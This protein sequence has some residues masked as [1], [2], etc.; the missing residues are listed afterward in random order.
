MGARRIL[1]WRLLALA[2]AF[3]PLIISGC[4]TNNPQNTLQHSGDVGSRITNLF[5]PVFWLA[6][7][8]FVGVEGALCY[9]IFRFRRRP[10]QTELPHQTHG[11]TTLEITWTIIPVIVLAGIAF[12][13]LTGIRYLDRVPEN[14][15][16]VNVTA[17]QWWWAFDYP[18]SGIVTANEM[19]IPAGR[20]VRVHLHSKDV[21]HSFWVPNLAGKTDV[22]PNHN[23]E[24]WLNAR[25]PGRYSGQCA[26]F[27]ALSHAKMKFEVVALEEA[28][29]EA[30][31][32][33]QKTPAVAPAGAAVQGQQ[34]FFGQPCIGCHAIRGQ[35][36]DGK[37]AVGNTGPDLTHFASRDRFAGAWLTNNT[38]NLHNWLA[39][40]P[41][42]KPGSKMPN[43]NL[44]EEQITQ[45][46]AYLQ[47]LK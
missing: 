13:T 45:L 14:A 32:Q 19:V 30:W 38:T 9:I 3:L 16:D 37:Q 21:I 41:A 33:Q 31:V 28:D 39:D 18:D 4:A 17:Q 44:S 27:C 46:I 20:P 25:L 35:S 23:N 29:Y 36:V 5:Y 40:P 11:S 10:G 22:I 1:N 26:E 43:Y 15:L 2:A 24:M 47:S 7:A 34:V 8:V 6:V 42:I 12:P